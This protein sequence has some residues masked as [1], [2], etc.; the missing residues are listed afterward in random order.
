MRMQ[1]WRRPTAEVML[2]APDSSKTCVPN[3]IRSTS[4]HCLPWTAR[5]FD[6]CLLSQ[7]ALGTFRG[8]FPRVRPP[9]GDPERL[10]FWMTVHLPMS[11]ISKQ[12]LLQT[13]STVLRLRQVRSSVLV[14]AET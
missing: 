6:A 5:Q 11:P 14:Q 2:F 13:P 4:A 10:S 1:D 8:L 7:L 9:E 3:E 12:L